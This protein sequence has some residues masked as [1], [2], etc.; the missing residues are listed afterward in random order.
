MLDSFRQGVLDQEVYEK[1][2]AD[3]DARLSR[4]E[5][6]EDEKTIDEPGFDEKKA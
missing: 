5:S 6:G 2:L 1:L 4:L 3:I